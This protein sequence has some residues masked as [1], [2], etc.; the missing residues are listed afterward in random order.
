MTWARMLPVIGPSPRRSAIAR[1]TASVTVSSPPG[2][3]SS[4]SLRN[5]EPWQKPIARSRAAGNRLTNSTVSIAT[6]PKP[7]KRNSSA[8]MSAR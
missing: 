4:I 2:R 1:A 5:G 6:L 8:T 7:A 3:R